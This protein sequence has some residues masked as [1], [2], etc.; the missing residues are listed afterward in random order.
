MIKTLIKPYLNW[1]ILA[2]VI[3]SVGATGLLVNNYKNGQFAQYK[4]KIEREN[5]KALIKKQNEYNELIR[6]KN[7]EN[8]E[9]IASISDL[10]SKLEK[11]KHDSQRKIDTWQ[12][13]FN[14]LVSSGYRL[15]DPN[16]GKI[17]R[18]SKTNTNETDNSNTNR[19]S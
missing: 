6:Q 1:I 9:L 16:P 3:A 17:P 5:T 4:L 11:E 13:H 19:I 18:N 12:R 7:E 15:R 2:V 8:A 14:N 10:N